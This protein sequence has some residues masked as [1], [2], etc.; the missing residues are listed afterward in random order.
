[1]LFFHHSNFIPLK[2]VITE[3][4]TPLLISLALSS[5]RSI[6]DMADTGSVG[7][8]G[9]FWHL[10]AEVTPV[11]APPLPTPCHANRIH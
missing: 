2:Y 3:A 1:V 10:L 5:S 9:S 8:G 11:D 7:H 6:L 4:L